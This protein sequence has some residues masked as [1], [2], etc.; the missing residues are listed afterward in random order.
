M[1]NN[2]IIIIG[3]IICSCTLFI[4]A[5]STGLGGHC[6]PHEPNDE[7]APKKSPKPMN[8]KK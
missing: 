7:F 4:M 6:N 3:I 1:L 2:L 5:D 8:I